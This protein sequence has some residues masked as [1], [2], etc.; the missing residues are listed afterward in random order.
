MNKGR[1]GME[2][3][4]CL[5]EEFPDKE[6][7]LRSVQRPCGGSGVILNRL[8]NSSTWE[9][10]AGTTSRS[11]NCLRLQGSRQGSTQLAPGKSSSAI[12]KEGEL[13]V[14]WG[15]SGGQVGSECMR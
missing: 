13:L 2:S 1:E 6:E 7:G 10:Q 14:D 12:Q 8:E 11:E 5:V 15:L 9:G 4:G 3:P